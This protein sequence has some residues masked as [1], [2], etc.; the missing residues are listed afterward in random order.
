MNRS[1]RRNPEPE[2]V[3][4]TRI[5]AMLR[6]AEYSIANETL[7][8]EGDIR[9]D[10]I[11]R[12][13]SPKR[14]DYHLYEEGSTIPLAFLEAKRS[15][16]NLGKALDQCVAYARRAGQKMV[17]LASD[18]NVVVGRHSNGKELRINRI[19]IQEIPDAATLKQLIASPSIETGQLIETSRQ[20]IQLFR[21]ASNAL[22]HGGVDTGLDS[23]KAFCTLLFLKIRAE[24]R[25]REKDARVWQQLKDAKGEDL[26][27]EY[28]EILARQPARHRDIF[29]AQ[30]PMSPASLEELVHGL[31][32]VNFSSSKADVKGMAFEYFLSRYSVNEP[33]FSGQFFTPRH[34][35]RLLAQ[36]LEPGPDAVIY[37]PFCGTGG[38][39]VSC[40]EYIRNRLNPDDSSFPEQER[41]LKKEALRG[42]DLSQSA[43][44]LAKMNMIILGDGH[45]GIEQ[46]DSTARGRSTAKIATHIITN[47]PFNVR[48]QPSS[49]PELKAYER[50]TGSDA[51]MNE[52]CVV[53]CLHSA[54]PKAKAAIIVPISMVEQSRYEPFRDW[55]CKQGRIRPPI[56]LRTNVFAP[57]AYAQ[58]VILLIDR[59]HHD[60]TDDGGIYS[61]VIDV[62]NDGYTDRLPRQPQSGSQLEELVEYAGAGM[63]DE[64]APS[65]RRS[66]RRARA[67]GMW[68]LMDIVEVRERRERLDPEKLYYEPHIDSTTNTVKPRGGEKRGD[69]FPA[70]A[71][72]R[73]RI[74]A[75]P[76]D[77][78]IGTL[79]TNNNNGMF[80][81]ADREY[82]MNSGIAVRIKKDLVDPFWLKLQL[83]ERLPKL[84][85]PRGDTVRRE[86]FQVDVILDVLIA[87]PGKRTEQDLKERSEAEKQLQKVEEKL[88]K[89][90]KKT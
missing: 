69:Q 88:A 51:D 76:G 15:G 54:K 84:T 41:R 16:K 10:A 48:G 25:T 24:Q 1:H 33:Q 44:A 12:K 85:A 62:T 23:L 83:N 36:L 5:D 37:D 26:R 20:L 61:K 90:V 67:S 74:I 86:K 9:N 89:I 35:T 71:R 43:S 6:N 46:G 42:R 50:E 17:C 30:I 73:G 4:R 55:L 81:I 60:E 34:I 31:D 75:Q 8:H 63:L 27:Q 58:T 3:A 14:P 66:N 39:L 32:G 11:R 59:I 52:A 65:A 68:R 28:G 64:L 2:S 70:E 80:A 78:L 57:Y 19:P 13:V 72:N 56:A 82:V 87:K 40:F 77:L 7:G 18:G 22:R 79:H 49:S 45:S 47:I 21:N 53:H 29:S 38:M